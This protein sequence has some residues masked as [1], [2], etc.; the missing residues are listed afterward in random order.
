MEQAYLKAVPRRI[1]KGTPTSGYRYVTNPYG[2]L[3]LLP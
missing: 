3:R 2:P 1:V